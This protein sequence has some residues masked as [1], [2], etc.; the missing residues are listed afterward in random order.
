MLV[1]STL[2][3]VALIVVAVWATTGKAQELTLE[4]Q[5]AQYKEMV[6]M[7]LENRSASLPV[8]SAAAV[9]VVRAEA[10]QQLDA[11]AAGLATHQQL[12]QYKVCG[13]AVLQQGL[14]ALSAL[15]ASSGAAPRPS[16]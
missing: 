12:W 13:S 9:A 6:L 8:E 10:A 2:P 16:F 4:Q 7:V 1:K 5:A 15:Q 14:T 3:Y 11:C